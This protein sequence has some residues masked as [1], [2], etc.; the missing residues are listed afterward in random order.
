MSRKPKKFSAK[1][2]LSADAHGNEKSF[3]V[4]GSSLI[5]SKSFQALSPGARAVYFAMANECKG[6]R[7]FAF[8]QAVATKKYGI[9]AR[10]LWRYVEEL[11]AGGWIA[12]QSGANVRQPNLYSFSFAWK[13]REN[14]E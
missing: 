5:T 1:G 8:P 3:I 9:A 6:Q 12:A 11:T 10:S 4:V 13:G 14:A 7:D 2:W